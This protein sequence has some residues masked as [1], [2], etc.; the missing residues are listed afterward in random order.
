MRDHRGLLQVALGDGRS[1][2]ALTGISLA[3]AGGFAVLQSVSGQLLPQDSHAVGMD[4]VALMRAGNRHL[5]GFMF[6]DR[7]AYGGTLLSIGAGYLWLA[8]FPMRDRAPWPWWALAF[9]G[10]IGF[11]AFLTYLGQGYLDTW[12]GVATLFLL[13]VFLAGL[14]RSRPDTFALRS[15]WSTPPNERGRCARWGRILLGVCAIGLI[16]AGF[17]IAVFGMTTVFV[18][19]DLRFI[20]L[21]VH[22]LA[23]ISPSL[24]PVISHDRAGFG[25]GLC[26]IG[27]LLLF[28]ARCAELNRS[29][30]EIVTVMG[31]AGFGGA[32]TVHFVVGYVDF[33]HLLPAFIGFSIFLLADG[34]LYAGWRQN[35]A[36][37]PHH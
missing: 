17:T 21:D 7:V 14:W 19:S 35:A 11:L 27:S 28:M 2:I 10:A 30:A 31:C 4:S 5:L 25:G 16:L 18:P 26:S 13:P 37:I 33:F 29:F 20:G 3:L 23:Q 32:I 15:V 22:T 34:F 36:E 12:H 6:H 24:I 9:S 8:A 1:L